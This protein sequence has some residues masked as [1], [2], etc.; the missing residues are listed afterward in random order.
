MMPFS[1]WALLGSPLDLVVRFGRPQVQP[2]RFAVQL[3]FGTARPV[4]PDASATRVRV[5]LFG[6]AHV[7]VE[8]DGPCPPGSRW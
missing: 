1:P 2:M 3:T 4:E 8:V 7:R 5:T 6:P